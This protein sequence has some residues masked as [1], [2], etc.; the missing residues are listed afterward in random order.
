MEEV[1][2]QGE[3]LK[4]GKKMFAMFSKGNFIVKFTKRKSRRASQFYK[5][6][7]ILFWSWE[8]NEGMGYN[9]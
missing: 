7:T 5:R 9:S 3:S 8:N 1:Q 6:T 4:I 2:K